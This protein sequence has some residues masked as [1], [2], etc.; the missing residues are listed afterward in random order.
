MHI[1]KLRVPSNGLVPAGRYFAAL[2]HSL[3]QAN[4]RAAA[5]RAEVEEEG[6]DLEALYRR[7]RS[8]QQSEAIIS[9]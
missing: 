9:A 3:E 1:N 7:S 2:A 8:L 6:R 5:Q 4:T